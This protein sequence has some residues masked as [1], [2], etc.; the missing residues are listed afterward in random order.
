[1]LSLSNYFA[2]PGLSSIIYK[3]GKQHLCHRIVIRTEDDTGEA[4]SIVPGSEKGLEATELFSLIH[5][6]SVSEHP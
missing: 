2:H 6:L 5:S 1:M 3:T 4:L